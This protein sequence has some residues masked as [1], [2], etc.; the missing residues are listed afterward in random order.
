MMKKQYVIPLFFA[1]FGTGAPH[2][3]EADLEE[4]VPVTGL[5]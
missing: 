3:S 5:N 1:M 2:G 4:G